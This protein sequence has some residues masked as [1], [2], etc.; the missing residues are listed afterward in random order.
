MNLIAIDAFGG[1]S[2]PV[3]EVEGAIA[4]AS[5]GDLRVLLCGD[6]ERLR[7]ELGA[8]G[9]ASHERIQ[10]RHATQVV[11]MHDHPGKVFRQKGDSSLRVAIDAVASGEAAGMVSA[12][13]SGAVLS[14]ALF[15]LKRLP[16]VERPGIVTAFPTPTGQLVLCDMGAN[17][18]VKPTMLAQFGVLGAHYD[19]IVHGHPRPR[20][21]LLANGT[22]DS[23]GTDL[24]RA[25]HRLLERA[26]ENP[27]AGFD[28]A[29]YVEGSEI[30]SG[31]VD[32][33][34]TDGF[35]GNVVLKVSEGVAEAV[36]RMVRR[37][38][39]SSTRA[40][41]G[42]K[43]V[44]PALMELRRSLHY[45]DI[46]GAVLLGVRGLATICH[47]RSDATAIKNAI[48]ATDRFAKAGLTQQLA[49]A[50][51]RHQT[52]WQDEPGAQSAEGA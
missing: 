17:V 10:I 39:T 24:T 5:E 36:L 29:G 52:L 1:D 41:I 45:S 49:A 9:A 51:T 50:I 44:K 34:A 27:E 40:K 35:T 21:G 23:K 31:V 7:A 11:D 30:F 8:R 20:V 25:A 47:G 12:G 28:F 6:E 2:A 26:A 22:E 18:D 38:V 32:V 4:A 48:V 46:G 14:H 37:A 16:D 42:A 33:V 19:R 3:P 15:I 13:N 43:L